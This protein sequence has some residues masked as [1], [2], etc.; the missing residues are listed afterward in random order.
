MLSS[1]KIVELNDDTALYH[2]SKTKNLTFG[3]LRRIQ[4]KVMVDRQQIIIAIIP[5]EILSLCLKYVHNATAYFAIYDANHS[6]IELITSKSKKNKCP[7]NIYQRLSG[8]SDIIEPHNGSDIIFL[9]LNGFKSGVHSFNFQCIQSHPNDKIGI[10]SCIDIKK[11][12]QANFGK[13][14]LY[15]NVFQHRYYWWKHSHYIWRNEKNYH[16]T[17][18]HQQWKSNDFIKMRI[19]CDNWTIQF[20]LNGKKVTNMINI[21]KNKRYYPAI[22]LGFACSVYNYSLDSEV[23]STDNKT[24]RHQKYNIQKDDNDPKQKRV[25]KQFKKLFAN[26]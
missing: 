14:S 24:I 21:H 9:S 18:Q 4:H 11:L 25:F 6:K 10:V 17:I 15:H 8:L 26:K 19:N 20:F 5:N 7:Y 3:Y 12:K 2:A 1:C 13:I 23:K 22:A 16:S